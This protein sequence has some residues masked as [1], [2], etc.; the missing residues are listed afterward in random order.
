VNLR[1]LFLD[2]ATVTVVDW[3]NPPVLRL[4]NDHAHLGFERAR[5]LERSASSAA[6][7]RS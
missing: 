6:V 1:R 2:L 5:W 3:G 7:S 4:W